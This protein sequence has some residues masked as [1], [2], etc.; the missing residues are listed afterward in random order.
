MSLT[1]VQWIAQLTDRVWRLNNLYFIT[2]KSGRRVRFTMNPAQRALYDT[3]HNQNVILKARQRGFTTFIQ[4]YMLDACLFY[5]NI[6]AGTIAHTLPDAEAIFRD[7]IKF[8][9]DNLRDEIKAMVPAHT[10]NS[11]EL[12]FANNSGI[13]VGVS[14]RS[15]TLQYLHVSEYGKI[16]A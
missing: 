8:P 7:K 5:K 1:D 11:G 12:L 4:L 2:D 6:R 14:L 10:D 16:C 3:M 13:R 15:A 9:Y